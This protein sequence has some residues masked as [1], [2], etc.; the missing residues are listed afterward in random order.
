M[1]GTPL[2]SSKVAIV[3]PDYH[4]FSAQPLCS[5][6]CSERAFSGDL[7]APMAELAA[8]LVVGPLVSL[9]KDKVSSSLLDQYNL[10]E[11]MEKQH[12]ILKRK[13]PAILDVMADAEKQAS[14]RGGVKAWLEE[15][16]TVAYEANSVFDEFEY[17]A[18]RRRAKKNG[19]ITKLSMAGVKLFPTHNRVAFRIRMGNKLS[20]IVEAIK[21]LVE[22][23]KDFGFD[24]LQPEAPAWQEWRQTDSIIVD[25]ENIV[26]RSRDKEREKIIEVLLSHQ[27][28]SG[29]LLVLPIVGMG[30]LGKTTLAQL[31]YNDPRVQEHFQLLN[32]VCVSDDFDVRNLAIKICDCDASKTTLEKALN[33]LQEH[34]RGKRYLLVLDDV[35][36]KDVDKWGKL[37][38]C[39]NQGGVGSAIL[40]TTRDKEIAE[41]MGTVAW[42]NKYH[43]VAILDIEFIHEIIETRAFSLQ[44]TKPEELVKLVGSIVERCVGSPLA[45]KALG[46]VLRN[47][48]TKEEWEDIL[49]RS[50][51]CDD[52]T[53]I[54]PILK[55][56]YND[57][58]TDMKQCFA[59]C[60][61]YPKDYQ[62]DVEE[63]IQL[64]MA[65]GYISD[66]N[67]VPAETMGKRIVNEM[68][69][70][71]FFQYEEQRMIGYSSTTFVKIH[72]LMHDVAL[73][74]SEKEC[75][76]I[77]DE[78]I[79]SGELLPS[80]A[81]HIFQRSTNKKDLNFLFGTTRGM[82]PP[83]QTM[84]FDR[85]HYFHQDVPHSSKFSS[86][87][88]LSMPRPLFMPRPKAHLSI[89]PKHLCHLR[90]LDLSSNEIE[91]LP[92][93][94]S[95]LYSLQTL[96]LSNCSS[97]KRLP[98]QMKHMSSLC[99]L[100]TDGCTKLECMPPEFGRITSLRTI[101]WFVVGSGLNCSSLGELKDLNVG[102]SLMLKQLENV[103]VRRNAKAAN[104]ENKKELRQLSLEWT[105]GKEDEQQ[106][107]E[108][109]QS[110]EAHD[111]LLA[112]EIYSYQG[113]SFPSWMGML[114][115][116]V[117]LRLSNCSKADQLPELEQ[118]A[119]LQVL[120]LEG[121]GKLQFLCS[122]CTS[123]TFGK[124]KDL[125]LLNLQVFDR[126]WEVTHGGT[127]IFPQL[128]ILH[129]EGCKNLAAL[130]EASVLR[131]PYGGGDYTAA[132]SAFPAL[133]K[134]RLE[135][136]NS[137]ERWDTAIEIEEEHALFPLLEIVGIEK[138][139]K[140]T[141]LP[142]APKV[143]EL[144]MHEA[145]QQISLG[146]IRCMMSLSSL[147]LK[148]VKL[149]DK[150]K[151]EHPSSVVDMELYSCSL[152]FQPRALALWVCYGQLQDLTI[153]SCDELVYWPEK[154]FQ[155]LISLRRIW[156]QN[157][158][159][160]I[161][162]AA[163]NAPDQ[164]TSGR[165]QL[166]PHIESVE[167]YSCGSL[168]EVFNSPAL[169][170][171]EVIG[172]C[173]LESLYGRQQLNQEASSTHDVAASTPVEEKLVPSSLESLR[174]MRCD[175]LSVVVN[176]PSSL[177][178]IDIQNCSKL[179]FISGQLD[180]L[181]KLRIYNCPELRSLESLCI[182]D[183]SALEDLYL[184]NCKSLSSLPSGPEPH[185]YSSLRQLIIW[186]CPGIKSLPSA[187]QQRL[188]SGLVGATYLDSR[189]EDRSPRLL[190]GRLCSWL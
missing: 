76:C 116:M 5:P 31:I 49:H 96:K 70:R 168:V 47:K 65:N 186:R 9:L 50:R 190:G 54:L 46:S 122:S 144:V 133:K 42:K 68:V 60:A 183:L 81:R 175:G 22:E 24:K 98:E 164:E 13:L 102:G 39:L 165:S 152:F 106:C 109:L 158:N 125:K 2:F 146:G 148:G 62:I 162:Y 163:A 58:P 53:G 189:L 93:D 123:S 114:K 187:L 170:R 181:K 44:K 108:V 129:I 16:K 166:L 67:K 180:A 27:A 85:S 139:P 127:V 35:W 17:E 159:N 100:Y 26:S 78:F 89:K 84:I 182:T 156:I 153:R 36:N 18:L 149:D 29:D 130:P 73:S 8:S 161:G 95:I 167:I 48:T 75:V 115:N 142:R 6:L 169:K 157:C 99:H 145:N 111:G 63:L 43:D 105:S 112:L 40:T 120:H 188:E 55:L 132:R 131:E 176:L 107:H 117:E 185:E 141:T 154:V 41:F 178:E 74:A 128:E 143:K 138:C 113:T 91:A 135:D 134:L 32:W 64:W 155:S 126:F 147:S 86:L 172:C 80:A 184:Y 83:I 37:K 57:L 12:K 121:L 51:I 19:H 179:R 15:L 160:L 136:L 101:T 52:E 33:K 3:F 71:S 4:S 177:R 151:W 21:V 56:S 69:S 45:A 20:S 10:M 28:S 7:S 171:M 97:L 119:E 14:R 82:F 87:R 23:M 88:A 66:Q 79:E 11:G 110:L 124:L 103:T 72:D 30:G 118:L 90:Y 77:T 174:I 150:E 38:A 104:L 61:M 94:I 34:L 59:F 1:Q 25:P 173:K 137:F 140:L 92:D